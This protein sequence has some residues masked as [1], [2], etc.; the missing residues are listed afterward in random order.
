MTKIKRS[1]VQTFLNITPL[2]AATYVLLG[3][4]VPAGDIQ[5]NPKTSE[6][7]WVHEDS[8]R[9]TVESYNP[10]MPIEA[11]AIEGDDAFDYLDAL[12][13][14]RA[15]LSDAETDVVNVW[16][17]EAGGPTAYPAEQQ[18]VSIQIEKFGGPGG[19]AAKIAF[20]INYLGDPVPGTFNATTSAF[21]PT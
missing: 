15:T 13:I 20:T 11:V 18:D 8:G 1:E 19:E 17:Y 5:Y 3:E 16:M 10:K 12:R 4:G 6:E 2:A 7:T 21:T 9:T 14:A